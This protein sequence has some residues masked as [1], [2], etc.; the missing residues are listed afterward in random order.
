MFLLLLGLGLRFIASVALNVL[1][2][3]NTGEFLWQWFFYHVSLRELRFTWSDLSTP[4]LSQVISSS[5][6]S[7]KQDLLFHI[8]NVLWSWESVPL[9][10]AKRSALL[11]FLQSLMLPQIVQWALMQ[12][13]DK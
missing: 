8:T 3:G 2:S 9:L 6:L 13:V 10:E 4:S 7:A 1:A 5:A 11:I 12:N